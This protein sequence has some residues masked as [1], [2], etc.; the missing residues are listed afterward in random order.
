MN[1]SIL[2]LSDDESDIEVLKK[3][4]LQESKKKVSF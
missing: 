1:D 3:K 2:S 4:Y